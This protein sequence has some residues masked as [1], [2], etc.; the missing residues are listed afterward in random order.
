LLV[1]QPQQLPQIFPTPVQI[2]SSF[3]LS[4]S[5]WFTLVFKDI[6]YYIS[7]QGRTILDPG[8]ERHL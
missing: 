4:P 5:K 1:A 2:A 8:Q 3:Y 6:F 7:S